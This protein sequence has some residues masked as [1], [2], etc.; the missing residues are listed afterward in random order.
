MFR[1]QLEGRQLILCMTVNYSLKPP[2]LL[3]S[4]TEMWRVS[5]VCY[6]HLPSPNC[7]LLGSI[8]YATSTAVVG[9]DLSIYIQGEYEML[10]V[11]ESTLL[12]RLISVTFMIPQTGLCC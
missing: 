11:S 10:C 9:G 5:H 3:P 4:W 2:F 8:Y 6:Q 1:A 12:K 7:L